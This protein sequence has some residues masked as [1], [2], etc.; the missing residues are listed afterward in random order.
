[1]AAP[2]L[3]IPAFI[4]STAA[5][6]GVDPDFALSIA[7]AE[8]SLN[9]SAVS[10]KGALGVMQLMPDTAKAL[11]VD[12]HDVRQ[13]IIGGVKNIRQ[14]QDRYGGDHELVAAAYNAGPA[15]VDK[16][17]GV[18]PYK[19]T[20]AYIQKVTGSAPTPALPPASELDQIFGVQ[21]PATATPT[22]SG[23]TS[24]ASD[25]A[26]PLPPLATLDKAF[27]VQRPTGQ[28]APPKAAPT[29]S[30]IA[31]QARTA[32]D[33]KADPLAQH[34]GAFNVVNDAFLGAL[35]FLGGKAAAAGTATRNALAGLGIGHPDAYTPAD[36]DA[37]ERQA[38]QA[39]LAKYQSQHPVASTVQHLATIPLSVGP[40][41]LA[42][43][44][45]AAVAKAAP[46]AM[47]S[48][49]GRAATRVA[50]VGTVGAAYGAG[51]ALSEGATPAEVGQAAAETGAL[52]IPFGVAGEAVGALKPR[53]P[54]LPR[55]IVPAATA[56]GGA[57]YGL[58]TGG[59]NRIQAAQ[60]DALAGLAIGV[61]GSRGRGR[62]VNVE[63]TP[64]DR[65]RAL[66]IAAKTMAPEQLQ[67]ADPHLTTFEAM[68]SEGHKLAKA[69][70]AIGSNAPEAVTNT[71]NARQDPAS[72]L[73]R[74]SSA[75]HGATG[76][77]PETA[78][79]DAA[80]HVDAARTGPSRQ[81]YDA[82]ITGKGVWNPDLAELAQ[83]PAVAKAMNQ[84]RT[85]LGS[86]GLVAN[87]AAET[88]APF[89]PNMSATELR[90]RMVDAGKVQPGQEVTTNDLLDYLK[91]GGPT[92]YSVAPA[93]PERIPSDEMWD[94]TKRMLDKSV[95][96]D[97][98][99]RVVADDEN[100]MRQYWSGRV[101]A[102]TN[103]AIPGLEE[104]RG[105]AGEYLSF[106]Q[107]QRVGEGLWSA[108]K[109]SETAAQFAKRYAKLTPAEQRATQ[110]GYLS[111]IHAD[112]EQGRLN[113]GKALS[114][115][116]RALQA[117]LFGSDS[118]EAI[119]VA[120]R[121]EQSLASSAKSIHSS[122]RPAAAPE[123]TR[124][125]AG[126]GMVM[127]AA[128]H[129]LNPVALARGAVTGT[130]AKGIADIAKTIRN[131]EM[132]PGVRNALG[133]LGAQKPHVTA[134]QI[135]LLRKR[136]AGVPLSTYK[137]DALRGLSVAGAQ[138]TRNALSGLFADQSATT[139]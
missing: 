99:G 110:M 69:S 82:A 76:I 5:D 67:S 105:H 39:L 2:S 13:N 28:P 75:L 9:P 136:Q 121:R 62:D 7:N 126:M 92:T 91:K 42:K 86:R 114:P 58:A 96:H 90:A 128:D 50:G 51:S 139:R 65:E 98:L 47:K 122:L 103:Q 100:H 131:G 49:I 130:V 113:L 15:A 78:K 10:P 66:Q 123:D 38:Y 27:G 71:I 68:G 118:A 116:H 129:G 83:E 115:Y 101:R 43:G 104:A 36:I 120:F 109:N 32:R 107:A 21:R 1:M 138:A 134:E 57:A 81:A 11:G 94:W 88:E 135:R 3:D 60:N 24:L 14:L 8:S 87:P 72:V 84:A 80:A 137:A 133:E 30:Q 25:A 127:A 108:G 6:H 59:D 95:Q 33:I 19:E 37:A 18:P 132:T 34:P 44:T 119:Q 124:G 12:P 102:A 35:P 26:T 4:R 64:Q 52:S 48:G 73:D 40:R 85:L 53:L 22:A 56:L 97:A 31:A 20:Q 117:T 125:G 55:V 23:A 45:E 61:V 106:G 54:S 70:G 29:A 41:L 17:G 77:S 89:P 16:H 93:N 74:M 63:P 79:M 46:A 112:L 111:R